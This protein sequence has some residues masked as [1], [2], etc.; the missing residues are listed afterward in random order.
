MHGHQDDQEGTEQLGGCAAMN[1][2]M[3]VEAKAQWERMVGQIHKRRH[4][5][6]ERF[7]SR[8]RKL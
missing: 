6:H 5:V 4:L 2:D 7:T 3:D 1:V 8:V